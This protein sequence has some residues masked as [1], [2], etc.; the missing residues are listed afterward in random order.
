MNVFV[1]LKAQTRVY[2]TVPLVGI[3][4][5]TALASAHNTRQVVFKFY[6][7][8]VRLFRPT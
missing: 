2:L 8:V 1:L 7:A 4:A 5:M 3:E 6:A